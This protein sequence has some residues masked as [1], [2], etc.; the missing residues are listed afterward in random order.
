MV[1][2]RNL[3]RPVAARQSGD[4]AVLQCGTLMRTAS[5]Y[6]PDLARRQPRQNDAEASKSR[7]RDFADDDLIGFADDVPR[8]RDY[9]AAWVAA[10]ARVR[11]S[12]SPSSEHAA[13]V[14]QRIFSRVA[15]GSDF[16]IAASGSSKSKCG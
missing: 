7:G 1:A 2:K 16:G 9:S 5:A 10:A 13:A 15:A 4:A 12:R 6:R 3:V 14:F 8:H 11:V